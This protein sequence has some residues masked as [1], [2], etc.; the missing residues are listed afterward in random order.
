MP[1]VPSKTRLLTALGV[2]AAV[3]I[4][5]GV[6]VAGADSSRSTSGGGHGR[7][8]VAVTRLHAADGSFA[9]RLVIRRHGAHKLHVYVKVRGVAPGFHGFHVHAVGKCD[10]GTTDP[11]TGQPAPFLS[12]GGHL[13]RPGEAHGAHAGDM[14]P[15]Y[16]NA[17]GTA[18]AAF[19]TDRF[20]RAD[21]K[22]ADGSA[23]IVHVGPDNLAHIPPRYSTEGPDGTRVPGPDATTLATGDA[24]PRALCGVLKVR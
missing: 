23:V 4:P 21:L 5:A 14:P 1:T 10:P 12:A 8:N 20:G 2:T 13:A 19:T 24:G 22:D 16:V 15:L 3:A 9:G 6:A 7:H 18:N 17:D 11:A